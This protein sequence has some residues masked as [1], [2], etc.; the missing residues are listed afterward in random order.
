MLVHMLVTTQINSGITR[1]NSQITIIKLGSNRFARRH[2][3]RPN[4]R[5]NQNR[6]NQQ[7]SK[8]V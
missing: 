1:V 2:K 4:Y 7:K 3:V 5:K 6:H 8:V